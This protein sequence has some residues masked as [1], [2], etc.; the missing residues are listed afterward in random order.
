MGET[1]DTVI[2]GLDELLDETIPEATGAQRATARRNGYDRVIDAD[3][4]PQKVDGSNDFKDLGTFYYLGFNDL[5]D[6]WFVAAKGAPTVDQRPSDARF[7]VGLRHGNDGLVAGDADFENYRIVIEDS[8]GD[9]LGYQAETVEA[10]R[11]YAGNKIVF[12]S[13]TPVADAALLD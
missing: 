2:S 11:T 9:L 13:N 12:S 3:D 6:N 10:G 8:S 4:G 1:F 7:R 5:F